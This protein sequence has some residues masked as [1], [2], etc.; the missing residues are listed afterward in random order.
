MPVSFTGPVDNRLFSN[1]NKNN[2]KKLLTGRKQS[3]ISL[4]PTYTIYNVFLLATNPRI[5]PHNSPTSRSAVINDSL[6]YGSLFIIPQTNP[7]KARRRDVIRV[8]LFT[9][10]R[11]ILKM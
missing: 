9:I 7:G 8:F 11:I 4:I 10:Y 2:F 1:N 6:I 3:F 5:T